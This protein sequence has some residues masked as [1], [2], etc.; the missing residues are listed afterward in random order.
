MKE[1]FRLRTIAEVLDILMEFPSLE[2]REVPSEQALRRVLADAV[3]APAD[4]PEFTRSTVD[5]FAVRARD[6]F[7]ASPGAP[8]LLD[9]AGDIAMGQAATQPLLPGQT[10]RLATGGMLPPQADA[11]VM[12]EYTE[13]LD[14]R[15]L[16]VYRAVSPWENVIQQGEDVRAGDCLLPAGARLRPQDIGMLAAL[17]LTRISVRRR[18]RVAIISTGDEIVPPEAPLAPGCIRDSN[19]PALAAQITAMGGVPALLGIVPDQLEPLV[20][21]LAAARA[22]ADLILLS[23]GSSVGSRDWALAALESFA[24]ARLLVHGVAVSPGKPTIIASL[25]GI[26][27]FGLPGHP[28]SAMIIME[29][30]VRPLMHRLSGLDPAWEAWGGLVS[31]VLSRNV[32]SAQGRDDF[33]RVRLRPD[34]D[35]LWADPV[36][37]KSG[38]LST[39]VKADGFIRIGLETEGLEAGEA[40]AVHLFRD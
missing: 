7:G 1:F 34:A 21:R 35:R 36:L 16:E 27:L 11:V 5:G 30:F 38:L 28:V 32:A 22:Q 31:A 4:V 14:E 10:Q 8:A 3:V 15:T 13:P 6:T 33:I 37:G 29:I 23:G 2:A 39:L 19:A 20:Q 9:L 18:P 17:G 24:D 40:V 25:G 26:P 12:L